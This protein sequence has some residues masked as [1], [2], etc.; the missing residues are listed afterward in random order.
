MAVRVN[1]F[2]RMFAMGAFCA[3]ACLPS[4][5]SPH[6]NV[7]VDVNPAGWQEPAVLTYLNT[8]TLTLKEA[9]LVLRYGSDSETGGGRYV[10]EASSPSGAEARDT[11]DVR[12]L[13]ATHGN[14]LQET[15]I[16]FR[17]DIILAEVGD[18]VFKV[19][20]LQETRGVWSVA[21]DFD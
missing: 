15:R 20:P 18:Y 6:D 8:D 7:A 4:C 14:N 10:V 1:K 2:G 5:L 12:I 3:L 21:I 16:P 13:L 17:D 9:A 19:T 11:L